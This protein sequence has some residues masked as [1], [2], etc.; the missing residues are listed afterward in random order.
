MDWV[1]SLLVQDGVSRRIQDGEQRQWHLAA[2]TCVESGVE[3]QIAG[4]REFSFRGE[5]KKAVRAV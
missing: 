3:D 1:S 5:Q 4:R 2:V